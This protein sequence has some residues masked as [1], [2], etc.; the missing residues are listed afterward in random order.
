MAISA[1]A[2]VDEAGDDTVEAVM[3]AYG[4]ELVGPSAPETEGLNAAGAA[5]CSGPLKLQPLRKAF[6]TF[7]S[8]NGLA[9]KMCDGSKVVPDALGVYV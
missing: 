2:A 1:D 5:V 9:N 8:P 6:P 7:L 4:P 3:P